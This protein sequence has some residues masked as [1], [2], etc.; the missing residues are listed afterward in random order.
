[1][2][3]DDLGVLPIISKRRH[4]EFPMLGKVNLTPNRLVWIWEVF[5]KRVTIQTPRM[6]LGGIGWDVVDPTLEITFHFE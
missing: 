6:V 4:D 5:S 1:M 3:L 2:I